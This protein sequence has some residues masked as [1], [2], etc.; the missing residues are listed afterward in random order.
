MRTQ[1]VDVAAERASDA[2]GV[3]AGGAV[4]R[5]D[6]AL[7]QRGDEPVQADL[8]VQAAAAARGERAA[9]SAANSQKCIRARR[10]QA[11]RP[12]GRRDGHV[13]PHVLRDAR[14]LVVRRLLQEGRR[15]SRCVGAHDGGVRAAPDRFYATYFEGDEKLAVAPDDEARELWLQYLP[16]ERVLPGNAKD[17][18]WEMGDT[19]PCGPCSEIHYDRI[20]GRDAASLVNMDD[21]TWRE[22]W[23]L[24]FMQFNREPLE[25]AG[26]LPCAQGRRHGHGLRA[27]RLDPAGT[28]GHAASTNTAPTTQPPARLPPH[29][30][31]RRT[32]TPTSSSDLQARSIEHPAERYGGPRT[33][34]DGGATRAPP[35]AATRHDRRDRRSRAHA[36]DG[37]R[38]RRAAVERGARL[39][40]PPHP[41]P[42]RPLRRQMLGAEEGFFAALVPSAIATAR[43]RLPGAAA[44]QA[45]VAPAVI[46]GGGGGVLEHARPR[47]QGVQRA[48]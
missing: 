4:R 36:V 9:S 42:R 41:P 37:D 48:R 15:A 27:P 3:V 31:M 26:P 11:Q 32:T 13:P 6:A 5:P 19:G 25:R 23:N 21:P 14:Q 18:F 22:V 46:A 34:A 44:E 45:R 28:S 24:V 20:G 8:R 43:A 30:T 33:T 2:R 29:R 40:P 38:R 12:R 35:W 39:R 47:H 16:P 7:L 10:R 1:F 17:N